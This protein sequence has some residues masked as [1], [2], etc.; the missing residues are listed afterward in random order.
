[1]YLAVLQRLPVPD[2]ENPDPRGDLDRSLEV[3]LWQTPTTKRYSVADVP[4]GAPA[5]WHG[6]EEAT[7]AFIRGMGVQSLDQLRR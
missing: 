6:E 1:V 3:I 7:D 2:K 4:S 5:W